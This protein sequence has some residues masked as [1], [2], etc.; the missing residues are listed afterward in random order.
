[1]KALLDNLTLYNTPKTREEANKFSD[2][3]TKK[4]LKIKS[5][6]FNFILK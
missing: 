1:M 3:N 5:K 6:G 2:K 4:K